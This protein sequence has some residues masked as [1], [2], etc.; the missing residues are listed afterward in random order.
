MGYGKDG[1][2]GLGVVMYW[3]ELCRRMAEFR[4]KH[5]QKGPN[6]KPSERMNRSHTLAEQMVDIQLKN[7][8][9]IAPIKALLEL[10]PRPQLILEY[11]LKSTEYAVANEIDEMGE[12]KVRLGTGV[13]F[14]SVVG[15]RK[16]LGGGKVWNILIP[17]S[18]PV[19]V[20]SDANELSNCKFS[21]INFPNMFGEDDVL[22]PSATNSNVST[23]VAQ[24]FRLEVSSWVISI[25]AVEDLMGMHYTLTRRGGSAVTHKG[26][27]TRIDGNV[28]SLDQL[29][30]LLNAL[31]LFLSFVRGSYCGITFL[32]GS[33]AEGKTIWEQWG[34][35]KVE[36][37]RRELQSWA[38]A[39]ESHELSTVFEGFWNLLNNSS[40]SDA[41]SQ[42]V[43]WYLRSNESNEPEVSIVLT[44]AALERLAN[45]TIGK[46]KK[47]PEN[48]DGEEFTR[49][50][51]K[52][53]L[54]NMGINS[55]LPAECVEL[56][57]LGKLRTWVHGPQALVSIRNKLVHPNPTDKKISESALLEARAL[58][59]HYVELM[60]LKLAGHSGQYVNRSKYNLPHHLQI[61]TVPWVI[62]GKS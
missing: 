55:T 58:G 35:Y 13:N 33:D 43:H 47:V 6:M 45:N 48:Q 49:D 22:K 51:I 50:W 11:E 60:L 21:L 36:A 40:Q 38:S 34:T 54:K 59:L 25:D 53:A 24:R 32:D 1:G 27:I 52:R 5:S 37:W 29:T 56:S 44:Q 9:A 30:K 31:H 12:V 42:V 17:K 46:K 62:G 61:E 39:S 26:T 14:D 2:A 18:E 57:Q 8:T 15:N 28:F 7:G 19:T 41:V 23:L 10:S 4:L 20:R 16:G 3:T